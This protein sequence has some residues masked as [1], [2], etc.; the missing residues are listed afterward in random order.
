ML[1]NSFFISWSKLPPCWK[2]RQKSNLLSKCPDN[3]PLPGLPSLPWAPPTFNKN[4]VISHLESSTLFL[5]VIYVSGNFY[6]ILAS[7]C[8]FGVKNI[9]VDERPR[10]PTMMIKCEQRGGTVADYTH[11]LEFLICAGKMQTE[12]LSSKY[13]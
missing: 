2:V 10:P 13:E 7:N 9:T 6:L 5:A 3:D 11:C 1:I 4:P 8:L 12:L